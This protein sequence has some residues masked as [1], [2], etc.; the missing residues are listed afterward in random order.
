[1]SFELK[2]AG[3]LT[4]LLAWTC[5]TMGQATPPTTQPGST[6]GA[7]GAR[8]PGA[9][10]AG[11]AAA[12]SQPAQPATQPAGRPTP[13]TTQPADVAVAMVN[14]R[15][16]MS[17]ELNDICRAVL[18][19]RK[20]PP[21][22]MGDIANFRITYGTK[23]MAMLVETRLLDDAAEKA[24]IKVTDDELA[25]K[26]EQELQD[27]LAGVGVTREEL[28]Q[29]VRARDGVSLK[30]LMAKREAD[31]DYRRSLSHDKL[32][33]LKFPDAARVSDEEV[34]KFYD[35]NLAKAFTKPDMAQISHIMIQ[36]DSLKTEAEKAAARKQIE[37]VLAE[38]MLPGADFAALAKK[39][40]AGPT[41]KDGGALGLVS[42]A[43]VAQVFGEPFAKAA[44]ALKPGEVSGIIE[45]ANGYHIIKVTDRKAGGQMPL[46]QV[47]ALI[48]AQI[49]KDNFRE[50]R[51]AFLDEL[52]KAAKVEYLDVTIAPPPTSGPATTPTPG[53]TT[54]PGAVPATPTPPPPPPPAP[55][56]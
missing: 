10:P 37:D 17:S 1:M 7:A 49:R 25:K 38:A 53:A 45:S 39:Y 56:P 50:K 47:K 15:P 14:G 52:K 34:K 29:Q 42:E 21:I 48:A 32:L 36:T 41:A 28:E 19:E 33:E 35:E 43:S 20:P 26:D 30:E 24:G 23:I 9:A 46:D 2:A 12:T 11:G 31:P 13:A 51:V 27:Y 44:F 4:L 8:T 22:T 16:I 6:A 54:Q 18:A 40:S 3:A 55:K 5:A